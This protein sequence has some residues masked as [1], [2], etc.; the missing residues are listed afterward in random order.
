MAT[1]QAPIDAIVTDI[2]GTTTAISFV[3]DVLFPYARANL[4]GF[5]AAHGREPAVRAELDAAKREAGDPAMS[6]EAVVAVLRR[7]ID[8]DRK[9]TP[10]KALQGMI[11]AEGYKAGGFQ[12][13]VYDD[14]AEALRRWHAAG[15]KLYVYSSGSVPAQKLIFGHTKF[16]DLTPL[17]SGYFDTTTGPKKEA[18]SYRR[19]AAAIGMPASRMLFLSDSTDEIAAARAAG[20]HTVQLRRPGEAQAKGQGPQAESFA[21]IALA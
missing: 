17:F 11:W 13:H 5:V 7:W 14:A 20:L 18:D 1:I 3:H 10:L 12:G 21:A 2:E 15:K 8:E 19:I 4:N 6:D 16:G 9:A